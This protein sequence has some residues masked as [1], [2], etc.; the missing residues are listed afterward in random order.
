MTHVKHLAQCLTHN[1]CP[2]N[3][4]SYIISIILGTV[5]AYFLFHPNHFI[6][7]LWKWVEVAAETGGRC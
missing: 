7:G 1:K 5:E 2:I 3:V 4:R 6:Q